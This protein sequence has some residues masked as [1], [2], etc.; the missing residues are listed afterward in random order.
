MKKI[1][2]GLLV[3]VAITGIA[4][5][6]E[7]DTHANYLSLASYFDAS[8]NLTLYSG[9]NQPWGGHP[10]VAGVVNSIFGIWSW[11]NGDI[12]GGAITTGL[13]VSGIAFLIGGGNAIISGSSGSAAMVIGYLLVSVAAPIYGVARGATQYSKMTSSI[14][15]SIYDNPIKNT[16]FILVPQPNGRFTG[17]IT[18]SASY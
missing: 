9:G 11:T 13:Y 15:G 4:S 17:S 1:V 3:L 12:I 7:E 5:A 18:Y 14:A 8:T 16:S 10:I 2:M 6:L